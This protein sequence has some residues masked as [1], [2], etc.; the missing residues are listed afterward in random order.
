[1]TGF[2]R[3]DWG[4]REPRNTPTPIGGSARIAIHYE[5]VHSNGDIEA[6]QNIQNYHMDHNGWNDI[7]YNWLVNK[8]GDIFEGRGWGNRS[9]ANGSVATNKD[10]YAICVLIGPDDAVTQES[11]VAVRSLVSEVR[12]LYSGTATDVVSH[13]DFV[14]TSCPGDA[15]TGL[16][17]DGVF[18]PDYG[19]VFINDVP[20]VD[21]VPTPNP[22]AEL[23]DGVLQTGE[24]GVWVRILQNRLISLGFSV[25]SA[26]ADGVYGFDTANAVRDFQRQASIADDGVAGKQTF[27]KL[28]EWENN[29]RKAVPP[30]PGLQMV[31]SYD[32][33]V[34]AL[35][36]Q[37]LNDVAGTN[38]AVD[39]IY[40]PATFEAVKRFQQFFGANVDGI[41]GK[42]T[43]ALLA[44]S[45]TYEVH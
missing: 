35:I 12:G 37:K 25:G 6:V 18:E 22:L 3:E 11:I 9:A 29:K 33:I 41:V 36:Q 15:L 8:A 14:A 38:L 4:A 39:G 17:R 31:G 21:V 16:V 45:P 23:A 43:W 7:A 26:G 10:F 13:K 28:D 40:G 20:V 30:F 27:A 42:Q 19:N 24:H 34:T 1:M 5:G 2:R 32:R 44:G